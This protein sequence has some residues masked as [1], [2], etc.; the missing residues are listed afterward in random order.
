MILSQTTKEWPVSFNSRQLVKLLK[1]RPHTKGAEVGVFRGDTSKGL[2][3]ALPGLQKLFCVD[4][5]VE[6]EEFKKHCPN[7]GGRIFNANWTGVRARFTEQVLEPYGDRVLAL[8]MMSTD[9]ADLLPNNELDWVFI[10]G[11]HGYPYV[12]EDILAWYPKVK[13]GGMITGD[14][15]RD[16]PTYGVIKAVHELF[17]GAHHHRGRIWWAQ[18]TQEVLI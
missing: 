9:A 1:S 10:D 12:R 13:M 3:E 17:N 15:Y 2:L 16:R 4:P 18:K 7:K 8:Q 11:N 5:W 14:D 6:L